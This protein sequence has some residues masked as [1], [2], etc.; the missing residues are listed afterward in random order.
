MRGQ[1]NRRQFF[2]KKAE[3]GQGQALGNDP[4]RMDYVWP[5]M[6]ELIQSR[7]KQAENE[8]RD[9]SPLPGSMLQ[10]GQNAAI[11][12]QGFH[13]IWA[14]AESMD[15][16]AI[17]DLSPGRS[18]RMRANNMH[19]EAV[20]QAPIELMDETRLMISAPSRI[21]GRKNQKSMP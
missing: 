4:V 11:L 2:G 19:F 14:V 1:Q 18:R 21:S 15:D 9:D 3:Q 5:D 7:G 12:D 10:I 8:K 20:D 16:D 17:Q 6:P 13:G